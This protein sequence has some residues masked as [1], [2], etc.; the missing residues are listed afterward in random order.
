[1]SNLH[2]TVVMKTDIRGFTAKVG[3]LSELDLSAL[4]T[5]HKEF[6]VDIARQYEGEIAKRRGRFFL[7][8][9]SECKHPH[10]SAGLNYSFSH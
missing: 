9:V 3:M 4:L 7:D 8:D 10:P 2:S 1:M 5:H 6:I